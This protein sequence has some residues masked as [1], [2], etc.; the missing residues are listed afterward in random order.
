[1]KAI[2]RVIAWICQKIFGKLRWLNFLKRIGNINKNSYYNGLTKIV[3]E[4]TLASDSTCID[5]GCNKGIILELMIKYSPNGHFLAFEP[6][7]T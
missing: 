1:M 3:M 4:K 6:L 2:K 7:P 5:I